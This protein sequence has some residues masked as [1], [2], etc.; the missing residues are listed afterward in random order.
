MC[1]RVYVLLRSAIG[2]TRKWVV[3]APYVLPY[4]PRL[5]TFCRPEICC[6][7]N[8][9]SN[10]YS[11]D[12]DKDYLSFEVGRLLGSSHSRSLLN[13]T[14]TLLL[15]IIVKRFLTVII[16]RKLSDVKEKKWNRE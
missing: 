14:I 5:A 3:V 8:F 4:V 6:A 13:V 11:K 2:T 15:D 1:V 12:I 9:A 10:S 7:T 16:N